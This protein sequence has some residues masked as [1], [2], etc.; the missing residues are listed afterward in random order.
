MYDPADNL[1][2]KLAFLSSRSKSLPKSTAE[3]KGT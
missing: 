1:N 3:K 2:Y